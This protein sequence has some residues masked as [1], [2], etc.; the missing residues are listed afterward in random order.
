MIYKQNYFYFGNIGVGNC[1][2]YIHLDNNGNTIEQYLKLNF[3]SKIFGLCWKQIAGN[4]H[5][6]VAYGGRD[7][8]ILELNQNQLTIIQT[9]QFCDWINSIRL[10]E[11]ATNTICDSFEFCVLSSH[12][13]AHRLQANNAEKTWNL[14]TKSGCIEKSTLYCSRIIGTDWENTKI[15]GGTAL[16]E[17]IIW[18][19]KSDCLSCEVYHRLSGHNVHI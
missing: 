7:L 15:F 14:L 4:I 18:S 8:A 1:I 6:I 17:L 10:Y 13:V 5:H 16:G 12:S 2:R 19:V 9:I 3:R 11:N